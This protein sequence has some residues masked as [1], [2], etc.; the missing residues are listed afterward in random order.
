MGELWIAIRGSDSYIDVRGGGKTG[1]HSHRLCTEIVTNCDSHISVGR[2]RFSC[3]PQ[4]HVQWPGNATEPRD[5]P[6]V[7]WSL[8][9][10]YGQTYRYS[11]FSMHCTYPIHHKVTKRNA[12]MFHLWPIEV[13]SWIHIRIAYLWW[14]K[15]LEKNYPRN[16]PWRPIGLWD[17][18]G[19]TLSRQSAHRWW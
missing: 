3:V 1:W 10:P 8:I 2:A 7:N 12:N 16:R 13:N 6:V 15:T 9:C 11:R 19:P 5:F 4:S 17:V 14:P 18:K